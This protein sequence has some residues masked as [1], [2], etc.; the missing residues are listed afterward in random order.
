MGSGPRPGGPALRPRSK[1]HLGNGS[2]SARS[3]SPRVA[4][5]RSAVPAEFF[6][7]NNLKPALPITS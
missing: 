1:E 5:R 2:A 3:I 7:S 4:R 6:L